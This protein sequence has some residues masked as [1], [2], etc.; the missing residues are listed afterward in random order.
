MIAGETHHP[1]KQHCRKKPES[2][3][4]DHLQQ[5]LPALNPFGLS[6]GW[7]KTPQALETKPAT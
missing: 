3:Q 2:C 4:L 7:P 5:G 1:V 6:T